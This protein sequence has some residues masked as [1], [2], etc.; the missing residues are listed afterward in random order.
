MPLYQDRRYEEAIQECNH[1]IGQ[2][3][4]Y[5]VNYLWMA[6]CLLAYKAVDDAKYYIDM[7]W[8]LEYNETRVSYEQSQSKNL[9]ELYYSLGGTN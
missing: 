8:K 1:I 2:D 3:K 9:Y 7:A 4:N 5:Y 6:N